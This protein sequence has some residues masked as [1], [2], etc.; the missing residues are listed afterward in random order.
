M[1]LEHPTQDLDGVTIL[2]VLDDLGVHGQVLED[3]SRHGHW[4]GHE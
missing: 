2:K 1:I 4:L 3:S